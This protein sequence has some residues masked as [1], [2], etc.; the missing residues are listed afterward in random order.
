MAYEGVLK[1]IQKCI[2]C[3]VPE[4]LVLFALS[5]EFDVRIMRSTYEDYCRDAAEIARVQT[6]AI[7]KFDYDWTWLQIDDCI[8]FEPLGVRTSG[9]ENIVRGTSGYLPAEEESLEALE[10]HGFRQAGRIPVLLEAISR[11][12]E[13]WGDRICVCGRLAAPFSSVTLT[14]GIQTT[15]LLMFDDPEF[16]QRVCEFFVHYQTEFARV[17]RDAGADAIWFG[18][19]N[20]SSHLISPADY[21]RWALEPARDVLDQIRKM[22]MWSFNHNSEEDIEFIRLNALTGPDVI[23]IGSD[24]DMEAM[25]GEMRGQRCL[26]GNVH[27]LDVLLNGTAE[28]VERQV[29]QTVENVSRHGGHIMNSGEMI[30]RDTP[31][32]NMRAFVETTRRLGNFGA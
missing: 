32:Q 11:M 28:D 18:D 24:G 30:P 12:K 26:A 9:S 14:F 7:E 5:E 22:G 4:R 13:R 19:C 17:Q 8:E 20:A 16:V 21:Q 29:R 15:M 31:Q 25:Y 6:G 2:Q 23:S 10:E 1:D 27:P 3:G